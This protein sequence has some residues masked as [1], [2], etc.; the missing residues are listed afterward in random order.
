MYLDQRVRRRTSLADFY[1]KHDVGAIIESL[2]GVSMV[3]A[4]EAGTKLTASWLWTLFSET[5][6]PFILFVRLRRLGEGQL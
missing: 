3:T 1:M 4:G 5:L 2:R 6:E